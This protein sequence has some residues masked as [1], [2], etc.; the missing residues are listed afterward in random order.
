MHWLKPFRFHLF[1]REVP[2]STPGQALCDHRDLKIKH[3]LRYSQRGFVLSI[4]SN[5]KLRKYCRDKFL[6]EGNPIAMAGQPPS[7]LKGGNSHDL[8][9]FLEILQPRSHL[10]T[11]VWISPVKLSL[12]YTSEIYCPSPV[13]QMLWLQATNFTQRLSD[14]KAER[15][16]LIISM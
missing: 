4:F 16:V 5:S 6:K 7:I 13:H 12:K 15:E 1:L 8:L 3:I 11:E 9:T 10:S 14:A 2:G